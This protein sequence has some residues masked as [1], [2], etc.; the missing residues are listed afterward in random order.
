MRPIQNG[1]QFTDDIY[2]LIFL[3]ESCF[4]LIRIS[5]KYA[6]NDQMNN[7]AA[8]VKR[9]L[10]CA[11]QGQAIIWTTHGLHVVA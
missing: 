10:V 8:L 7:N 4:T 1:R 6:P 9:W 2:S 5:L 11:E 3:N